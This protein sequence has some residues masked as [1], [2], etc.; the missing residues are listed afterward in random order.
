MLW[1]RD[2]RP[3][4]GISKGEKALG[5]SRINWKVLFFELYLPVR[6]VKHERGELLFEPD[7][8]DLNPTSSANFTAWVKLL[9]VLEN[10]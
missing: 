5:F 9:S 1:Y 7:Y 3:G 8:E 10:L 4:S 6:E 2:L